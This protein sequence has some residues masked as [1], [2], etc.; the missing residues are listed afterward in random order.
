MPAM[1]APLDLVKNELRQA[2]IQNLGTAPATPAK[3]QMYMNTTDNTLYWYDGAQWIAAKAAAGA[4]PAATVTTQAVGDAGVVGVSTNFAREDHKHGRE[5]FGVPT[6]EATFGASSAAGAATTVAR[7]D[8]T[9]GNPVH[10]AAAHAAVPLSALA[11]ATAAINLGNQRITNLAN[12]VSGTDA[13]NL[14]QAQGLVSGLS[15][16]DPVDAATTGNVTLS[17]N[18]TIDGVVTP[19]LVLVKNQTNGAENGVYTTNAGA[20]TRGLAWD[21]GTE[22]YSAA[23]FVRQGTVNADT[24]WVC[25]NDLSPTLGTTPITFA[26]VSGPG[27]VVGGSGLTQ[28][29]NAL[30][31]VAGDTTL[32]VAADDVRV[33]T[34]VIAT[35]ASLA[36]YTPTTRSVTAGAGLTGGGTL[37][38]DRTLDVVAGDTTLTVAADSIVV[39]TGVIATVASVTPKADKATTVTAG[40]GL[41][42]GGDLSANRTLD[43][44]GGTGIT[45]AADS[46][47]VDTAVVAL[48]SDLTTTTR[49]F[50]GALTGT[51]AYA[52]GEVVTHSL[53]TRDVQVMIVNSATP[54]QAVEADWEATSVNTVTVRYNPNLG[55]GFRCVVMG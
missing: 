3:G 26:Q 7:S 53:N 28:T 15:W 32:T 34:S 52:T 18:Q 39:N 24:Q 6:A 55:A 22:F 10:D 27:S 47:S 30:N 11:A 54:W 49:K 1:Y 31:F 50:A 17:G 35:V 41:T 5:A 20:W 44:I 40:A 45:V 14:A 13:V 19:T 48:K 36:G 37:A 29:G 43:V 8:H 2:V 42:G 33:N 51:V 46:V 38:A 23:L 12:G 25:T 4:T 21:T 9:H 16:K